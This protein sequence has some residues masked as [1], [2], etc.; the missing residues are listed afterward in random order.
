M[1][2]KLFVS[3]TFFS[4]VI[5]I[6]YAIITPQLHQG[7]T[8]ATTSIDISLVTDQWEVKGVKGGDVLVSEFFFIAEKYVFYNYETNYETQR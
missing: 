5:V 8:L 6:K 7:F 2:V 3:S 4:W 1:K